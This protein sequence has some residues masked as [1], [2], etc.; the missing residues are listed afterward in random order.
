MCGSALALRI[1]SQFST[2]IYSFCR[3][4]DNDDIVEVIDVDRPDLREEYGDYYIA[5]ELQK[6]L[7]EDDKHNTFIACEVSIKIGKK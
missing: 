4:E 3:A 6:E 7:D 5:E 1:S 2:N